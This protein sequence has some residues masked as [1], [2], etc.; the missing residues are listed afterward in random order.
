MSR[1]PAQPETTSGVRQAAHLLPAVDGVRRAGRAGSRT[2]PR[3][4][5]GRRQD[6]WASAM[7][8]FQVW[9]TRRAL[10]MSATSATPRAVDPIARAVSS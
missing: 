7:T 9:H 8:S 1:P 4:G 3:G 6:E 10:G 5:G 2:S